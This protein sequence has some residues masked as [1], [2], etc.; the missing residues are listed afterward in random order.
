MKKSIAL[1]LMIILVLVI[2]GC[3]GDEPSPLPYNPA[4]T[5][6]PTVKPVPA[7]LSVDTSI[8]LS[9]MAGPNH[10]VENVVDAVQND[11]DFTHTI[12]L[13]QSHDTA[14]PWSW[15]MDELVRR[16]NL[17]D[18]DD[19]MI[20]ALI[21]PV[22]DIAKIHEAGGHMQLVCLVAQQGQVTYGLFLREGL[23]RH[24]HFSIPL[25]NAFSVH[26]A[27]NNHESFLWNSGQVI[28]DMMYGWS[29]L[30]LQLTRETKSAIL[31]VGLIPPPV[32]A[33]M[34]VI[35]SLPT[36][37]NVLLGTFTIDIT[38][39]AS[40]PDDGDLS[41]YWYWSTGE[42]IPM[43]FISQPSD[44]TSTFHFAQWLDNN[45]PDLSGS[46]NSWAY[47][48]FVR[49]VNRN[50]NATGSLEAYDDGSVTINIRRNPYPIIHESRVLFNANSAEFIDDRQIEIIQELVNEWRLTSDE[51]QQ[52]ATIVIEGHFNQA[53]RHGQQP[54]ESDMRLMM[55][56]AELV[57]DIMRDEMGVRHIEIIPYR[58][59]DQNVAQT[60]EERRSATI[61]LEGH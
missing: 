46:N 52:V 50:N 12:D 34:P 30:D 27:I 57:R 42:R 40:S 26:S 1:I 58:N 31:N 28:S 39:V 54:A 48:F 2:S 9:F 41:F 21:I 19:G 61:R 11:N 56:R 55:D 32:D 43:R 59:P 20:N 7:A 38:I 4:P 60:E 17:P 36:E 22:S 8:R 44:N 5:P 15:D 53:L 16:L 13:V 6:E 18:D 35:V 24:E 37:R 47:N 33:A 3:G 10:L 25:V 45:M 49:V 51:N 14:H 29:A 23:A